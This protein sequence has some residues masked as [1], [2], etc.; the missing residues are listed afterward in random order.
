MSGNS[1]IMNSDNLDFITFCIGNIAR[2][3]GLSQRET[4]L[5]LKDSGILYGYIVPCYDT[6]HTFS[7]EY[8]V[9][10]IISYLK[11]KGAVEC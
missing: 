1:I 9:Q 6:L 7:K 8:I 3:L 5:R 4:Y 10:D 2:R 11:E